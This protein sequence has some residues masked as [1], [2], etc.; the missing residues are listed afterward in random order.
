MLFVELEDLKCYCVQRLDSR[1][2]SHII[3]AKRRAAEGEGEPD[4]QLTVPQ[5]SRDSNSQLLS[6]AVLPLVDSNN[7]DE[8]VATTYVRFPVRRIWEIIEGTEGGEGYF[9]LIA[10]AGP[11]VDGSSDVIYLFDNPFDVGEEVP[12]PRSGMSLAEAVLPRDT[13]EDVF[14]YNKSCQYLASFGVL[15][16]QMH[17]G[18]YFP[19]QIRRTGP[20]GEEEL[21][22]Y[23]F[24]GVR[25][26][27]LSPV[28]ASDFGRGVIET[29]AFVFSVVFGQTEQGVIDTFTNVSLALTQDLRIGLF[30]LISVIIVAFCIVVYVSW[31]VALSISEPIAQL[32]N[33]VTNINR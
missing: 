33:L 27:S 25:L 22:N 6:S 5:A 1:C 8:Y 7:G 19:W 12:T 13:C 14:E 10:Q 15:V 29:D 28:N 32:W 4:L 26:V 16:E 20:D 2:F 31:G 21:V 3:D 23:N 18:K 9:R 11:Q 17:Q 24:D 30:V